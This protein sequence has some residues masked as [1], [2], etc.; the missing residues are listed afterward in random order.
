MTFSQRNLNDYVVCYDVSIEVT[1]ASM[2][3]LFLPAR[4]VKIN[5]IQLI[6]HIGV[7]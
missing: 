7:I 3:E 1:L 2:Q 5:N 6:L 4:L